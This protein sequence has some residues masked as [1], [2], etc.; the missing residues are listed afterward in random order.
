M[1]F[2][3]VGDVLAMLSLLGMI[4]PYLVFHT[5]Q[6]HFP[7]DIPESFASLLDHLRNVTDVDAYCGIGYLFNFHRVFGQIRSG[8]GELLVDAQSQGELMAANRQNDCIRVVALFQGKRE[9]NMI[10]GNIFLGSD[11]ESLVF[12]GIRLP[13]LPLQGGQPNCLGLGQDIATHPVQRPI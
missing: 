8:L 10:D 2:L 1:G 5:L 7:N 9:R 4:Y 3:F 11:I 12:A 6:Y 13:P